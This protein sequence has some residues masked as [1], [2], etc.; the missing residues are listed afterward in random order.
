MALKPK[1]KF[2]MDKYNQL[3][4]LVLFFNNLAREIRLLSDSI[5]EID[6][7]SVQEYRI[8]L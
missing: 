4:Q 7:P 6:E 1:D 2:G 3:L 8:T 5:D